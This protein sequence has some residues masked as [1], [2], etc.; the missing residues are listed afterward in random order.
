M[1]PE[2]KIC[3]I[4]TLE[5]AKTAL[6]DSADFLGFI[7][8]AKSP[9]H[10]SVEAMSALVRQVRQYRPD[11][12]LV[13]VVVDPDNAL[14]HALKSEVAPDLIQLHGQ[15]TPQRVA[16]VAQLMAVPVIKAIS[17]AEKADLTAADSYERV[18]DYLLFDAKTPKGAD[19]P[20]GMGLSFDWA[21]MRD[22]AGAKPWFLAGGL[23]AE[24][25]RDAMR[26]S[27]AHRLDVS[28][29]VESAPGV[30]DPALISRFLRAAKSL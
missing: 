30:K 27:G 2:I 15:E 17:L 19:L 24:N 1:Q 26:L 6:N 4:S 16:E 20:G 12:R 29:G 5:A 28:S 14:L 13:S 7:H 22:Y 21:I 25:A 18:A 3:G 23:T 10:L 8:F 9:R 11:A